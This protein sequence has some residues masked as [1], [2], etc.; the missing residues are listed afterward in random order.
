MRHTKNQL[1]ILFS[2][3]IFLTQSGFTR[4]EINSKDLIQERHEFVRK[5]KQAK[6]MSVAD[7]VV[8]E[9]TTTEADAKTKA[10]QLGQVEN[11]KV[12]YGYLSEKKLWYIYLKGATGNLDDT[13]ALCDKVRKQEKFK[14]VWLL[15]VHD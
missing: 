13:R 5:G 11:I 10:D 6:E 1:S 4:F 14:N 12:G 8:F 7:Y 2:I 9:T 15:T 3:V